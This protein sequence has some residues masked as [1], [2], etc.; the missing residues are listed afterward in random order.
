MRKSLFLAALLLAGCGIAPTREAFPPSS[1]IVEFPNIPATATI[2]PRMQPILPADM[3]DARAF[4]LIVKTRLIAGDDQGIAASV[5][6][7]FFTMI[8]GQRIKFN[9]SSEFLGSYEKIF[10]ERMVTALANIDEESLVLLSNGVR[11][12]TGEIWFNLFCAD[13]ACSDTQFLITQINP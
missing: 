11:A 12:G 6:Y 2:E 9:N 7:P 4:F 8:D 10:D 5:K 3:P 13:L 1:P